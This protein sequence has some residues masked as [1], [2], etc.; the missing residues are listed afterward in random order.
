MIIFSLACRFGQNGAARRQEDGARAVNLLARAAQAT[1][2]HGDGIAVNVHLRGHLTDGAHVGATLGHQLAL[3][4]SQIDGNDLGREVGS[5]SHETIGRIRIR[6]NRLAKTFAGT[7][8]RTLSA[9][10]TGFDVGGHVHHRSGLG[11]DTFA[12]LERDVQNLAIWARDGVITVSR[13]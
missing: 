13:D 3:D 1:T 11:F 8:S 7:S 2:A 10:N 6:V 9:L 12:G 5:E 4:I